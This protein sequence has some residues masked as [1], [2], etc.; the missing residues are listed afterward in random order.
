MKSLGSQWATTPWSARLWL[1]PLLLLRAK[2]KKK[3]LKTQKIRTFQILTKTPIPSWNGCFYRFV[4]ILS[5]K[6]SERV[7]KLSSFR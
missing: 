5:T 1:W 7:Q 2:N 3:S 6:F 4:N